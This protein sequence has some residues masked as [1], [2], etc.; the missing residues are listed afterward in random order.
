ML[1]SGG[2][3]VHVNNQDCVI[4]LHSDRS[5]GRGHTCACRGAFREGGGG[6]FTPLA[7]ISPPPLLKIWQAIA[8]AWVLFVCKFHCSVIL[9][10]YVCNSLLL[11]VCA[12]G[13]LVSL[14]CLTTRYGSICGYLESA[15]FTEEEQES[16][17]Q[18]FLED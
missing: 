5:W 7:I 2:S 1:W 4:V 6:A 14:C 15:G 13:V 3:L 16:L 8:L 18:R 10:Q 9:Y 12:S 17:Q 11:C